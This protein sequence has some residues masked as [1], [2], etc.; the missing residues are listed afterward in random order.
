MSSYA[1]FTATE[2]VDIGMSEMLKN[3]AKVVGSDKVPSTT[4]LDPSKETNFAR[5][6][7]FP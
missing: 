5:A 3:F 4:S 7:D 6:I 2:V 1:G